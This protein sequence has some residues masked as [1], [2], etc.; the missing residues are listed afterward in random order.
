M[1]LRSELMSADEQL[2]RRKAFREESDFALRPALEN[3]RMNY[4]NGV[5]FAEIAIKGGFALNGGAL[6]AIPAFVALLKV[7]P[8][9][10]SLAPIAWALVAFTAGLVF[11]WLSS[12]FAYLSARRAE[13]ACLASYEATML[14]YVLAWDQNPYDPPKPQN[15]E[16]KEADAK[17][18][19]GQVWKLTACAVAAG[20]GSGVAFLVGAAIGARFLLTHS[21]AI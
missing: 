9:K 12:F 2:A 18:F 16:T 21:G 1:A 14:R 4:E 20:V 10:V 15:I 19:T 6:I 11:A 8:S 5:K 13:A 3:A 17:R 7:D